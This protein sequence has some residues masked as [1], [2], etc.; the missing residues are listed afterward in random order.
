MAI[1]GHEHEK[2]ARG[3]ARPSGARVKVIIWD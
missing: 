2:D 3:V 1:A